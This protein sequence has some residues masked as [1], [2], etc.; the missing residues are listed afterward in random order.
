MHSYQVQFIVL[1]DL[2]VFNKF[3]M[4]ESW[5]DVQKDIKAYADSLKPEKVTFKLI[6]QR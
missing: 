3:F 1:D 5:A 6:D 4:G 2:R